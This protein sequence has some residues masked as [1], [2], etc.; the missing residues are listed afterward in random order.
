MIGFRLI[1]AT[2]LLGVLGACGSTDLVSRNSAT[3]NIALDVPAASWTVADVQV[4]VPRNLVT[5]EADV[6]YPQADLVWHGDPAGDRYAQV[7][8][9]MDRGITA[10]VANM[11]GTQAVNLVV[12]VRRFHSVTPKTANT[13]G[14]VHDMV[15]DMAVVDAETGVQITAPQT[16]RVDVKAFGGRRALKAARQGFTKKYRIM[17]GLQ[18]WAQT[19]FGLRADEPSI[20][21]GYVAL[22]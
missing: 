6:Y 3:E 14:G 18:D 19:E 8:E 9:L 13:V 10:G 21:E 5:T 17:A 12:T 16:Y 7:E 20:P 22:Y 11:N 2:A 1:A 4:T 15:F